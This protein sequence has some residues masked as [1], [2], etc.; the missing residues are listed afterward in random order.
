MHSS[1][2]EQFSVAEC[3][4]PWSKFRRSVR[5]EKSSNIDLLIET[6][7]PINESPL[8]AFDALFNEFSEVGLFKLEMGPLGVN[9]YQFRADTVEAILKS[10]VNIRKSKIYI[11]IRVFIDG[12]VIGDC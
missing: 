8:Q 2:F 9:V 3:L 10:L 6:G 1:D 7:V 12:R 5:F 4:R 11:V